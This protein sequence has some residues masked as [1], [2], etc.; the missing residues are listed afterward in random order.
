MTLE[1]SDLI[2]HLVFVGK[3]ADKEKL[4]GTPC[5][6]PHHAQVVH[7]ANSIVTGN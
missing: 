3:Q 7:Q 5:L 1:T 2:L 6:A 4:L